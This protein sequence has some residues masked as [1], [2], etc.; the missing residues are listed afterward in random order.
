M[1]S[2]HIERTKTG[3]LGFLSTLTVAYFVVDDFSSVLL[4]VEEETQGK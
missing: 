4:F 2:Q 3:Q 1:V